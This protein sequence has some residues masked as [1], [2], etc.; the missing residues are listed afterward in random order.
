MTVEWCLTEAVSFV[1]IA[2]DMMSVLAP[3][4]LTTYYKYHICAHTHL[5][6]TPTALYLRRGSLVTHPPKH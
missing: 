5:S 4:A 3:L 1:S 6:H 2:E